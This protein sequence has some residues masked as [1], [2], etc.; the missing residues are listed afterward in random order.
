MPGDLILIVDDDVTI[1][2]YLRAVLQQE[3]F[4][5]IEAANG[6]E[7]LKIMRDLGTAVDLLVSDIQMPRMDGITLA[8]AV[9][10]EFPAIPLILVSGYSS[11]AGAD[12]LDVAFIQKPFTPATLLTRI[13]CLMPEEREPRSEPA[14]HS[15]S[16]RGECEDD[17]IIQSRSASA[18]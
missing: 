5:T 18:S 13:G 17:R 15:S 1:R 7:A 11:Q 2:S 4:Q 10:R 16:I 3:G 8:R 14:N 9:R 6:L 12:D